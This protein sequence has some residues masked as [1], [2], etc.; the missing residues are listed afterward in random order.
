M[1]MQELAKILKQELPGFKVQHNRPGGILE[2]SLSFLGVT[3]IYIFR[4]ILWDDA[5]DFVDISYLDPTNIDTGKATL[6][7]LNGIHKQEVID[8][9]REQYDGWNKIKKY[10]DAFNLE[11]I[12]S[13]LTNLG[14]IWSIFEDHLSES[15]DA[16]IR[17]HLEI[18]QSDVTV[19]IRIPRESPTGEFYLCHGTIESDS[20]KRHTIYDTSLDRLLDKLME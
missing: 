15:A 20:H 17:G 7:K 16:Y 4:V 1:D 9:M 10:I 14:F 11:Y 5:D 3:D 8:F 18:S 19:D 2:G 13:T 12:T 6:R